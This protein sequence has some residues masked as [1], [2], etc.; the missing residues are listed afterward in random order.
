MDPARD[1][2]VL[3]FS[4]A[5]TPEV[6]NH[7]AILQQARERWSRSKVGSRLLVLVDEAPYLARLGR[8]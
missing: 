3:L 6:E 2:E 7:G 8:R 5:A 4:L 1:L